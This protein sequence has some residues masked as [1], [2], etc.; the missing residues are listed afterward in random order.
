MNCC[1]Y[2]HEKPI[3]QR[4]KIFL[5]RKLPL[6]YYIISVSKNCSNNKLERTLQVFTYF[7]RYF[8]ILFK[9]NEEIDTI[10]T[11]NNQNLER[12]YRFKIIIVFHFSCF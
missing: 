1:V 9:I 4:L 6:F 8:C 2:C 3:K 5:K 11:Y 7:S 10:D 12:F